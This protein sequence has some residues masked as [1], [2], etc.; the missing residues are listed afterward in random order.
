MVDRVVN[1]ANAGAIT[2]QVFR[3]S[4]LYRMEQCHK[5][6]GGWQIMNLGHK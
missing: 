6:T 1:L 5:E 3:Y 2:R 4:C